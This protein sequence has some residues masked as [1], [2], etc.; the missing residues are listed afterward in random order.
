VTSHFSHHARGFDVNLAAPFTGFSFPPFL[1][2]RCVWAPLPEVTARLECARPRS[3]YL[4]LWRPTPPPLETARRGSFSP[5]PSRNTH[6]VRP[7]SRP[8]PSLSLSPYFPLELLLFDIAA[9]TGRCGPSFPYLFFSPRPCDA[10]C[11][12]RDPPSI[13]STSL[14]H[15]F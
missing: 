11:S 14:L 10:R 1:P 4:L 6:V 5:F 13:T 9:R 15:C 3:Q 8:P 12:M 7:H 2:L